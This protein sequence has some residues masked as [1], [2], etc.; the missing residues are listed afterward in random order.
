M[1]KPNESRPEPSLSDPPF[2]WSDVPEMNLKFRDAT[3]SKILEFASK[4]YA[5]QLI[6]ACSFGMEDMVLLDQISKMRSGTIDVLTLDTGRLPDETYRLWDTAEKRYRLKLHV[7]FPN[8][9]EIETFIKT[10]GVNSLYSSLEDRKQCCFLRKVKPLQRHLQSKQ[11][12]MTGMR[13][14]QSNARSQIGA[15]QWDLQNGGLLKVNPLWSW[16]EQ[17]VFDYAKQNDVPLHPWHKEGVPSIGCAPCTRA[18]PGWTLHR[19]NPAVDI[20]QGR[21]WWEAE[22]SNQECGLHAHQLKQDLAEKTAL[23]NLS[24]QSQATT[25]TPGTEP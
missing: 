2:T 23:I 7:A 9:N 25:K 4:E 8:A 20:R 13:Q 16:S 5:D 10:R 18:V 1:T 11:A 17:A 24:S 15:F 6:F 3:S 14:T 22:S 21:W 12:W 19:S